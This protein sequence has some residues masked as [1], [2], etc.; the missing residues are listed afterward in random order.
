MHFCWSSFG[1][2]GIAFL[3]ARTIPPEISKT[4]GTTHKFQKEDSV[5]WRFERCSQNYPLNLIIKD[6]FISIEIWEEWIGI[7]WRGVLR[8]NLLCRA[9]WKTN[10]TNWIFVT[11]NLFP[12]LKHLVTLAQCNNCKSES[13]T[14]WPLSFQKLTLIQIWYILDLL[15]S[16]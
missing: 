8:I 13:S 10:L 4:K 2:I 16:S 5:G 7:D 3:W 11:D 6:N 9:N 12:G 15:H 1:K 14:I